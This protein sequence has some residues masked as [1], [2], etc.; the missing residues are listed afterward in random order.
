[1]SCIATFIQKLIFLVVNSLS[2][3]LGTIIIL[4]ILYIHVSYVMNHV[5]LC[6][7]QVFPSTGKIKSIKGKGTSFKVSNLYLDFPIE[8]AFK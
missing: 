3:L 2:L 1:M 4:S 6:K 5:N 7:F 8:L